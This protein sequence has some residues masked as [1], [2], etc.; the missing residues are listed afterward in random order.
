MLPSDVAHDP[1]KPGD[2]GSEDSGFD[3][4]KAA[5]ELA[6]SLG[7]TSGDD[8][9]AGSEDYTV[10][11]EKE[12]EQLN[13]LL[14]QKDV[15]L[16]QAN[17][18]LERAVAARDNAQSEISRAAARIERELAKR[19]ERERREMLLVF[20]EINDDLDRAIDAASTTADAEKLLEGVELVSRVFDKKLAEFGVTRIDAMGQPF[21]PNLHDAVTQMAVADPAQDKTVVG[22]IRVGYRIGDETLRPARVAVGRHG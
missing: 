4:I 6:A 9:Q 17:A 5:E 8:A 18:A 15:E 13:M 21:D 7:M 10:T 2:G 19:A 22:V 14:D 12:I 1:E 20:I 16:A 3:A 11:L